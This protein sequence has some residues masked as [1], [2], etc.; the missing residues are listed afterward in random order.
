VTGVQTCALPIY[1]NVTNSGTAALKH[2]ALST[3]L[4][5]GVEI[6]ATVTETAPEAKPAKKE[7]G[8][9]TEGDGEGEGEATAATTAP[10]ST[11]P[12]PAEKPAVNPTGLS[13]QDVRDDR[14]L[15]YFDLA[16]GETKTVKVKLNAAFLGEFYFPAISSE[17]MYQ[18]ATRARTAGLPVKIMRVAPVAAA[19]AEVKPEPTN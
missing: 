8:A 16:A 15:S 3:L 6:G 13:Y 14:V 11:T 2:V 4:P 7:D 1:V 9:A 10:A 18:P 12:A 5:S 17:A 19:A